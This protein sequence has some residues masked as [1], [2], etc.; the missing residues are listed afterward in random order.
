MFGKKNKK[1]K[2]GFETKNYK[3]KDYYNSNDLVVA[4]LES[5]TNNS[6]FPMVETTDQ[7]YIFEEIYEDDNYRYRE[8]FTG[9]IANRESYFNYFNL[10]YVVAV[11]PLKK[12]VPTV[13]DEIPKL[14]LL[15][16]L[17]EVNKKEK[18]Q[19]KVCVIFK[20]EEEEK[21]FSQI[22]SELNQKTKK[23]SKK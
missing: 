17:N 10:P 14:S 8:V 15:L 18:V 12:V 21:K 22:A 2:L 9:F 16:L 7:R 19:N 3:M 11:V 6:E 1:E 20:D 4:C 5:V 23:K 13:C